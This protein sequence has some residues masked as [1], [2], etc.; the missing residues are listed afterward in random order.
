VPDERITNEEL[1]IN[2]K[3]VGLGIIEIP[4][5]TEKHHERPEIL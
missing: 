1:K 2:R 5:G 3:K 4:G